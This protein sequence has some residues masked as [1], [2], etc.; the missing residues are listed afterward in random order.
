MSITPYKPSTPPAVTLTAPQGYP[1][2]PRGVGPLHVAHISG[3]DP[4][5]PARFRKRTVFSGR[6]P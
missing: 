4:G 1:T 2:E 3:A 5:R 6:L